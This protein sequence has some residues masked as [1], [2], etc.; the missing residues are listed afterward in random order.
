MGAALL[1]R[2]GVVLRALWSGWA[3]LAALCLLAALWQAGHEAYGPFILTAPLDT[4]RAMGVLAADPSSWD[5]A[6]LTLQR[7]V[8]G[9]FLAAV[10]GII[11]GVV[12]GYCPA[13]L[14]LCQ[15]LLTVL[16][17]VPPIAWI[18]LAMIWF[19]GT[20]A[21][22]R[23]VILVSALPI[24]FAGAAEG[25]ATRDRGLD[26]MAR[27]FG[28][29]PLHR[30]LDAALPQAASAIFPALSLALGMAFKVAVM[31]ELLANA[32]G[33]GGALG[34]ARVQ[35]DIAQALAWVAVAVTLLVVVEYSL[36]QPLRGELERWRR[37]T[38][39]WGV[40]R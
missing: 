2:L 14:R 13:V 24:I 39:P 15:P 31:S 28:A 16:L 22:V 21:T 26:A 23:V 4:L 29:G 3:G 12:A 30:F 1:D 40:K 6:L 19:G 37:A 7:A 11:A 38:R 8:T 32:G 9:F 34:D 18:V 33:I 20:D 10:T 5:I 35:L 36:I 27:V 17:G 25:I